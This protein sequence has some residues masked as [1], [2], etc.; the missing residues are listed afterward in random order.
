MY[1]RYY[2]INKNRDAF[3]Q[4][5]KQIKS[6]S[7]SHNVLAISDNIVLK[8][9]VTLLSYTLARRRALLSQSV[10]ALAHCMSPPW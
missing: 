3:Q 4:L 6:I 2:E 8:L 5:T 7:Y 9:F 1:V 10:L